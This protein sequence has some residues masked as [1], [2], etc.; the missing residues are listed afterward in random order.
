MTVSERKD[1]HA[2][3]ND[4]NFILSPDSDT[5]APSLPEDSALSLPFCAVAAA[6]PG[7]R[8]V[9]AALHAQQERE[10]TRHMLL[11]ESVKIDD[12]LLV[13]ASHRV[14]HVSLFVRPSLAPSPAPFLS[15]SLPELMKCD[16]R[17]HSGSSSVCTCVNE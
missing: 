12:A 16:W 11:L 9:A 17:R 7:R 2:T 5:R 13:P 15:P 1:L 8:A 4:E 3:A 6:E 14:S 10:R